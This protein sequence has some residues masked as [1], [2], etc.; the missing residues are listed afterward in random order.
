MVAYDLRN[1]LTEHGHVARGVC[2]VDQDGY[3]I[4]IHERTRIKKFNGVVKYT[5][6]GETWIDIP[7]DS[8]VSMNMWGFT[9]CMLAELGERFTHFLAVNRDSL[10]SAEYYL[11]VVVNQLLEENVTT[12][13]VLRTQER[14][15]GV[16]YQGDKI[17]VKDAVQELILQG[18]YPRVLWG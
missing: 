10:L 2:S 17:R 16:T 14:W 12:V 3:L 9:P 4:T 5:E 1:T 8:L 11:P 7:G 15:F 6:N 13:K 18:V